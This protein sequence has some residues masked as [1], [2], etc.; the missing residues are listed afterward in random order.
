VTPVTKMSFPSVIAL[1]LGHR[2]AAAPSIYH[3]TR[4]L[5]TI[6]SPLFELASFAEEKENRS[7]RCSERAWRGDEFLDKCPAKV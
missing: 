3:C 5:N 2:P 1:N 7:T 6:C 4:T